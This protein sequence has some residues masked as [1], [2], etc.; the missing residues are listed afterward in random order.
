MSISVSCPQCGKTYDI[1][2]N[3]AGQ[4]G[5]CTCGATMTIP[6]PAGQVEAPAAPW[7][8]PAQVNPPQSSVQP[9]VEPRNPY[10]PPP[11]QN[12]GTPQSPYGAPPSQTPYGPP[13]RAAAAVKGQRP[14]ALTVILIVFTL[15]LIAST[16]YGAVITQQVSSK[17][18]ALLSQGSMPQGM[19]GMSKSMPGMP[20]GMPGMP[21]G[22]SKSMP[23]MP[24]G[25]PQSMPQGMPQGMTG[26]VNSAMSVG[27]ILSAAWCIGVLVICFFLSI[28]CNWARIT[29]IVLMSLSCASAVLGF[30]S[31]VGRAMVSS[32][33]PAA[34]LGISTSAVLPM[35]ILKLVVCVVF[36]V[37]L[38]TESTKEYCRK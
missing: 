9:P 2:D 11:N 25:M 28:G 37:I 4:T 15:Y 32:G 31:S 1:P 12:Y 17:M 34:P 29:M 30:I 35:T 3:R 6:S 21:Q 19:P 10:G 36:L 38:I 27:I 5:K 26:I 16:I 13:P 7:Q 14:T 8:S 23:G 33:A 22:M 20:Q 24:Q 18:G